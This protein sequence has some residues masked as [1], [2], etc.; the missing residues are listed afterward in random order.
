MRYRRLGRRSLENEKLPKLRKK[1]KKR[2]VSQSFGARGVGQ[3]KERKNE[4]VPERLIK[5]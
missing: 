2:T 4:T 3:C 1:L 5:A